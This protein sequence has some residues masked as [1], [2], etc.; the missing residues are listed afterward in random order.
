[1][2]FVPDRSQIEVRTYSPVLKEFSDREGDS[3]TLD[4]AIGP[5]DVLDKVRR[6]IP[7][8]GHEAGR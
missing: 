3:F 8:F 2:R 4:W 6:Q 5:A 7:V 1:M